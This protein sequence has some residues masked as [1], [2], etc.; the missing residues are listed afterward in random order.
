MFHLMLSLCAYLGNIKPYKRL[1]FTQSK[2]QRYMDLGA[3]KYGN[4]VFTITLQQGG[5]LGD[6]FQE[7]DIM[8]CSFMAG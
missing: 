7:D 8:L 1:N 3:L 4:V 6:L 2:W 5:G